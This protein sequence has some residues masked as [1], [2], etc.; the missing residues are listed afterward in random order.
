[1]ADKAIAEM[2]E[3]F[4]TSKLP[5]KVHDG[6]VDALLVTIRREFYNLPISATNI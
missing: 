4:K 6:L 5:N 1:M 3:I 2:D